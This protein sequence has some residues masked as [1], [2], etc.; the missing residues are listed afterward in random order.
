[1]KIKVKDWLAISG[2]RTTHQLAE[3]RLL[4][5]ANPSMVGQR[6]ALEEVFRSKVFTSAI[7]TG[8]LSESSE[9]ITS[10]PADN[11]NAIIANKL[12]DIVCRLM[13]SLKRIIVHRFNDFILSRGPYCSITAPIGLLGEFLLHG[14]CSAP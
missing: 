12:L 6:M 7:R 9:F 2:W 13:H 5:S 14:H 4:Q 11:V 10:L 3:R 8:G 1:M